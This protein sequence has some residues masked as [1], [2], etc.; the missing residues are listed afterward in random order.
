M[1]SLEDF[2]EQPERVRRGTPGKARP[3]TRLLPSWLAKQR[4]KR[5]LAYGIDTVH[6]TP[7]TVWDLLITT[8]EPSVPAA[9]G[10]LAYHLLQR[11]EKKRLLRGYSAVA[12]VGGCLQFASFALQRPLHCSKERLAKTGLKISPHAARCAYNA[13]WWNRDVLEKVVNK[14]GATLQGLRLPIAQNGGVLKWMLKV[15]VEKRLPESATAKRDGDG[16]KV[17]WKKT[18]PSV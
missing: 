2:D 18:L 10:E 12:L 13:L 6:L 9:V 4:A 8:L 14:R 7:S 17:V 1:S 15:D 5:R 11:V 16:W 3:G